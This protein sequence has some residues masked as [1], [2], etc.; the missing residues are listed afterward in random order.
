MVYEMKIKNIHEHTHGSENIILK[1]NFVIV[2]V[3]YECVL[4]VRI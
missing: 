4:Y 2:V 1:I 3:F